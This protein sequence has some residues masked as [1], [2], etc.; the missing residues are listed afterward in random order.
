[1]KRKTYLAA[2]ILAH[3][4]FNGGVV[5]DF[6]GFRPW[7][8]QSWLVVAMMATLNTLALMS[9]FSEDDAGL[10]N[11][12]RLAAKG[13]GYGWFLLLGALTV[14]GF[15]EDPTPLGQKLAILGGLVALGAVTGASL[16][17]ITRRDS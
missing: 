7:T 13:L 5:R 17:A 10:R 12:G 16:Y 4:L 6:L 3:C 2:W 9:A 15:L 14:A 1:M 8:A 11:L